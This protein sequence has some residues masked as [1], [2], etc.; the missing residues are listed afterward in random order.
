MRL[1]TKTLSAGCA[2]AL[3]T[4][5]AA[6]ADSPF[7]AAQAALTEGDF[8]TAARLLHEGADQGDADAQDGLAELYETGQGLPRADHDQAL[9]WFRAAADQGQA[10]AMN[11]L[12]VIYALGKGVPKDEMQADVWF[13]LAAAHAPGGGVEQQRYIANRDRM[14]AKLSP[15]QLAQVQRAV[16]AWV[17][18]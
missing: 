6:A 3:S 17:T 1:W 14:A 13:T 12:G 2:V 7:A 5:G 16:Q 15:E 8:V 9:H 4:A 11:H 18:K 10:D